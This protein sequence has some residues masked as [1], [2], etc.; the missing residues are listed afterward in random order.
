MFLGSPRVGCVCR[1]SARLPGGRTRKVSSK[2]ACLCLQYF[3]AVDITRAGFAL[4]GCTG[5]DLAYVSRSQL[6]FHGI[7]YVFNRVR[8]NAVSCRF[9]K[10]TGSITIGNYVTTVSRLNTLWTA[11]CGVVEIVHMIRRRRELLEVSNMKTQ[12]RIHKNRLGKST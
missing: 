7:H 9:R 2:R 3:G 12:A 1:W 5:S 6:S 4:P 8:V 11:A 10:Q